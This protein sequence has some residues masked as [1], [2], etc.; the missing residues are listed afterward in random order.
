MSQGRDAF[1]FQDMSGRA[2]GKESDGSTNT[3][4]EVQ[5]ITVSK[6]TLLSSTPGPL[7]DARSCVTFQRKSPAEDGFVF[8]DISYTTP[9][10]KV[11]IQGISATVGKGEMLA[12]M[13]CPRSTKW[14]YRSL[15]ES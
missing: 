12:I 7:K 15:T 3:S 14:N 10:G 6:R 9:A 13:V 5:E 2:R 1:E 4:A 11:L 8:N